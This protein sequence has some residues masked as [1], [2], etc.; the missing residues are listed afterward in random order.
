ME[1]NNLWHYTRLNEQTYA[2]AKAALAQHAE[3]V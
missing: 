2:Q 3:A 1:H